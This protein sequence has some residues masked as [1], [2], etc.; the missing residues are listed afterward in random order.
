MKVGGA[1]TCA[2][3]FLC[4]EHSFST[5][6]IVA[7]RDREQTR[8]QL[9]AAAF[10]EFAEHGVAGARMER[11]A[12]LAGCSA[13]LAYTYFSSKEELFDAVYNSVIMTSLDQTPITPEDLPGYAGRLF[14]ARSANPEV[15]R[16]ATWYQLERAGTA[17]TTDDA[18]TKKADAIRVAQD[19]GLVTTRFNAEQILAIVLSLASMWSTYSTGANPS[20]DVREY[21]RKTVVD[22][23][24]RI[25]EP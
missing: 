24:R 4:H 16:L 3:H 13:G 21:Q 18:H 10:A 23:V 12:K 5:V 20:P 15:M 9:L 19:A 2:A 6:V 7:T 11:I 25:L 17:T 1:R 22:A 8:Q 14:D